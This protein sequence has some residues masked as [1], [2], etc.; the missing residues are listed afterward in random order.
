MWHDRQN[1]GLRRIDT[2]RK[3]PTMRTTNRNAPKTATTLSD[4]MR[5]FLP[6]S[7]RAGRL[8]LCYPRSR[9]HRSVDP[10]SYLD[11]LGSWFIVASFPKRGRKCYRQQAEPDRKHHMRQ[12]ETSATDVVV[13][14]PDGAV[15]A[16]RLVA[17]SRATY[18]GRCFLQM[19]FTDHHPSPP[20]DPSEIFPDGNARGRNER[21]TGNLSSERPVR[22]G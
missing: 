12:P 15:S 9:S 4:P 14:V 11:Y 16:I 2:R 1:S 17:S 5:E 8:E 10:S 19:V 3:P 21:R 18:S 7:R 13:T 20:T 6:A 22:H